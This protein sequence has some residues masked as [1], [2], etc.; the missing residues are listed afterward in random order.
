MSVS[1]CLDGEYGQK[2]VTVGV[3]VILGKC[4]IEKILELDLTEQNKERFTRSVAAVKNAIALL[5]A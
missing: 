4:G 1:T 2:D 3:P 5:K